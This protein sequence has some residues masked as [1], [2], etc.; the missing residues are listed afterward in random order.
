LINIYEVFDVLYGIAKA[1][2]P[3]FRVRHAACI[4]YKNSF[5]SFG[6]NSTKT[7]P[8]QSRYSKHEKSIYLH[9]EIDAIKNARNKIDLAKCKLYVARVKWN[10]NCSELVFGDSRPCLGCEK[11]IL[12]FNLKGVMWTN[13]E[14]KIQTVS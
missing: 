10:D 7:H 14:G 11:A 4:V 12:K 1:N 5:I 8:F 9:A 6:V 2:S 3:V 13:E